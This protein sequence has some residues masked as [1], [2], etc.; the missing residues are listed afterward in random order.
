MNKLVLFDMDGTLI[1]PN[2]KIHLESFNFAIESVLGRQVIDVGDTDHSGKTDANIIFEILKQEKV[3]EKEIKNKTIEIIKKME[4]FFSENVS[5]NNIQALNGVK[6]LL[7]E[8]KQ[9]KILMGI[10]TGNIEFIAKEK[11]KLINLINYFK[12]GSFGD[13][14]KNRTDLVKLAINK[15]KEKFDFNFENNVFVIGDTP[16]DII[17]GKQAGAI[18]L[19]VATGNYSISE[20]KKE[21]PDFLFKDLLFKNKIMKIIMD[22]KFN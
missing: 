15:A 1:A 18:T 5:A 2:N 7:T 22:D 21:N 14:C 13:D 6:E 3:S 4:S 11:L 12:I 9:K 17:A 16:K 19:A 20:L 8:I 10:V